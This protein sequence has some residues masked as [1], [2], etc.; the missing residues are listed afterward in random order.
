MQADVDK[1]GQLDLTELENLVLRYHSSL[2]QAE[3]A[4]DQAA[5]DQIDEENRRQ[6]EREKES[7][8]RETE[9]REME[10][11]IRWLVLANAKR[12]AHREELRVWNLPEVWSGAPAIMQV[13]ESLAAPQTCNMRQ[14]SLAVM[15]VLDRQCRNGVLTELELKANCANNILHKFYAW[16][17]VT[18][19]GSES[20]RFKEY[21][22]DCS[23][24][25][26]VSELHGALC[27]YLRRAEPTSEEELKRLFPAKIKPP[28]PL[29]V[30]DPC[31]ANPSL[32][33]SAIMRTSCGNERD[34]SISQT[35]LTTY[36]TGGGFSDFGD[37]FIKASGGT[38]SRY[39]LY[40]ANRSG[41]IGMPELIEAVKAFMKQGLLITIYGHITLDSTPLFYRPS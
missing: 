23:G 18:A 22:R 11:L 8:E 2:L 40:D 13:E 7:K 15:E 3:A 14:L 12:G 33:A 4:E 34:G 21:D 36:C 31:T 32:I 20:S 1:S 30:I 38:P 16:L 28:K 35:E 19:H 17:C 37:W 9:S 41:E 5:L 27:G 25:I 26:N 6:L 10:E 39:S 24:S 29:L